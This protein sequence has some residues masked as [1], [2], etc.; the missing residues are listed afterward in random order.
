MKLAPRDAAAY[1]ARPDPAKTGILI[2]GADAMRVALKRQELIA[3]LIGPQGEEEMRLTRMTGAELRKEPARLLDALK[4]TGF[5]PGPRVAFVE[6]ATDGL[7]RIVEAALEDWRDGDAQVVVTAGSLTAR[8][9]LR[10]LFEGHANAYATGI[11]DDPPSRGEIEAMMA[12]AQIGE[13]ARDGMDALTSLSRILDPGDFAQTLEKVALYTRGQEAPV[14]AADVEACAP[15]ST[16]A[17]LDDLLNIVAEGRTPE[18]GP[19]LRRLEAQGVAPVALAIQA[20]RHFRAL[21]SAA[22]DPGGAAQGISR[23]RPPVFGPR[24]DRMLRQA[25]A[26][27]AMKLEG[28]LSDLTE[29]DLRLRSAA[30]TAPQMAL[31]ERTLIRVAMRGRR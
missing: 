1:F 19:M 31:M 12:R 6:E 27:G 20:S 25:Q 2:Y 24:R 11:Y 17:A 29:T 18:L 22:S 15:A 21:H 10:K 4:A 28:A 9:A 13:V 3:A 16:D 26:W 7:A 30:Q 14:S 8:S 5:F 23:L